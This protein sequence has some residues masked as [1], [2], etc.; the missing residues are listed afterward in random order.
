ML[1][2]YKLLVKA[3]YFPPKIQMSQTNGCII[4]KHTMSI[5]INS[6]VGHAFAGVIIMRFML[7]KFLFLK[8]HLHLTFILHRRITN[9][10]LLKNSNK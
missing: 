7:F 3:I 8:V 5:H 4:I 1:I 9:T 10:K 2:R 6:T